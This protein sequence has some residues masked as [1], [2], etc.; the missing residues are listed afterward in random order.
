M[1]EFRSVAD[2]IA[3]EGVEGEEGA[4]SAARER[5]VTISKRKTFK[6]S[7][8]DP[9][10]RKLEVMSHGE[11]KKEEFDRMSPYTKW[12][13]AKITKQ[14]QVLKY[15][16]FC[17]A[18]KAEELPSDEAE[19]VR[20]LRARKFNVK[21]ALE[22]FKSLKEWR[23]R[24]DVDNLRV[25]DFELEYNTGAVRAI[26]MDKYQRPL[27]Y[28]R[29][30]RYIPKKVEISRMEKYC[31]FSIESAIQKMPFYVDQYVVI[32]DFKGAKSENVNISQAKKLMPIFSN[33]YPDRLG[34]MF[35]VNPNLIMKIGWTTLKPFMDKVTIDKI[36]F[37]SEKEMTAKMLQFID[38]DNLGKEYGGRLD[39]D[40]E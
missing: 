29:I 33:F 40:E 31:I 24:E 18:L 6:Y 11:E 12:C 28:V 39:L 3:E 13:V 23:Q 35:V 17:E 9:D 16:E 21:K 25:A 2:L 14:K 36:Q 20:V 15:E 32:F 26:G 8:N 27:L 4:I 7:A 30:R 38:E 5:A 1:G 34:T 37:L 22:M 10:R 19:R